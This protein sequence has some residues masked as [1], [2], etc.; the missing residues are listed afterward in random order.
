MKSL[1]ATATREQRALARRL[2]ARL[3]DRAV[4]ALAGDWRPLKPPPLA[5]FVRHCLIVEKETGKLIPFD[6]WPQQEQALEVIET[7]DKLIMPKGRQIG[8]TWL[9][10]AAMLWAGTFHG[11]RLFPVARQ[12]DEYAREAI[13]RLLILAGYDPTS[14]PQR[15]KVL[16]ESPLPDSWRARIAGKTQRELRFANGSTYRALTATRPIAR[17]LA[18]YWGLADEFAFWPWPDTQL[19]AME[20]GC[21]RLHIVSTGNGEDDAF[22]TLYENAK[23]GRGAYRSL[24]IPST[25]DPRRDDDWYRRNVEE[26]ADPESAR[27]EHARVVEDAFRSP[28]G[29]YFKRF[30]RERHVKEIAIVENWDTWRAVDFGYK[31]PACL[32]AQRSP[33]GQLFIVDELLPQNLATQ[34]FVKMIKEREASFGLAVPIKASYCDP[35]GKAT[36]TQTA[37]SEFEIFRREGL[38]PQGKPSSVRDG[39]VR[40]MNMLADEALPLVVSE[41][42]TGLIR[43]LSQVKAHRTQSEIYDT[44]H[45]IFAH[46]LDALRYLLVNLPSYSLSD[47]QLPKTDPN[48]WARQLHNRW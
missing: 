8:V 27:R 21:S 20:S 9:E 1:D 19:Q 34:E 43:A 40:I 11:H 26:A 30:A 14:E 5:E 17:G 37:E 7:T 3:S 15:L 12:S 16:S 42:C 32:W 24:F 10:L 47:W 25:A 29:V 2:V 22:A 33:Q 13:V 35:A 36:N 4:V 31:H 41:R 23:A 18:A 28:E 44:D 38:N 45:E 39:C 6:L 46:P 48:F